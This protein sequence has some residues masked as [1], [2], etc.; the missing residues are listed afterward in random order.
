MEYLQYFFNPRHLLNLRPPVMSD[1]A[2]I[3]LAVLFGAFIAAAIVSKILNG[4]TKDGLML[5]AYRKIFHLGLTIGILG[6]IY[7]FF[8]IEG[9]TLLSNRLIILLLLLTAAIWGGF[10]AK[11]I[12]KD[13]PENRK[14]IQEKR[15]F[16]KYIP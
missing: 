7:I 2:A 1:R 11:Y 12:I 10:I 3:I 15:N 13:V 6:F 16:E 14:K 5:K 8:A 9:V 4:K